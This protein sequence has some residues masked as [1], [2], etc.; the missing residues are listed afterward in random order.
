LVQALQKI[1]RTQRV[2]K[3][4]ASTTAKVIAAST[5]WL[6]KHP[7]LAHLVAP[8]AAQICT[9]LLKGSGQ[10][11]DLALC[12][13][14]THP[15]TRPLWAALERLTYPGIM[16]HYWHR[17]RWT[18]AQCRQLISQ[19]VERVIIVGAG[20][21]TLA[22][23]LA[24]EFPK[25]HWIELDHPNTQIAKKRSMANTSMGSPL[26]LSMQTVDLSTTRL[27]EAVLPNH[28]I[29]LVIV[30]G[31]LMYLEPQAVCNFM[32][33]V[34]TLSTQNVHLIFSYMLHWPNGQKGFQPRSRW[35]EHWLAWRGEPFKW[36]CAQAE[37]PA[38]LTEQGYSLQAQAGAPWEATAS[39]TQPQL[40]GENLVWCEKEI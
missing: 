31:V 9:Q 23:R 25:V 13:S 34:K 8:G 12:W 22:L 18:E 24:T 6:S 17:K 33:E 36:Y 39:S 21:D 35:I 20:F 37:L 19:G 3:N 26:N 29:T 38:W 7:K 40:Q 27:Q 16:A 5:L 30:E 1:K 28:Q 4:Q 14:A 11:N 2:K 15:I 32:R 10:W